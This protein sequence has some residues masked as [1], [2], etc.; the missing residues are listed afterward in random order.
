MVWRDHDDPS[1]SMASGFPP[2][3]PTAVH[4]FGALHDTAA[5]VLA[6]W[7]V[8]S[9]VGSIL[10][11]DPFQVAARVRSTPLTLA[12]EPTAVQEFV[13]GHDTEVKALTSSPG[14]L[15]DGTTVHDDPSQPSTR[16][17]SMPDRVLVGADGHARCVGSARHRWDVDLG[18]TT[19]G[20]VKPLQGPAGLVPHL[21]ERLEEGVVD[22]ERAHGDTRRGRRARDPLQG[23]VPRTRRVRRGLDRPGRRAATLGE[24]FLGP[25]APVGADRRARARRAARDVAEAALGGAVERATVSVVQAVPFQLSARGPAPTTVHWSADGHD[26]A[27]KEPRPEPGR[28]FQAVPFQLSAR[29]WD[30]SPVR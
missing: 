11:V 19:P 5:S 22:D 6:V 3:S 28:I 4:T 23:R 27:F 25:T 14:G 20:G 17:S 18:V 8:E 24:R 13:D 16:V 21:G 26:T 9:G 2:D 12:Q 30:W 7:P 29:T 1:Q 15:G 10:H